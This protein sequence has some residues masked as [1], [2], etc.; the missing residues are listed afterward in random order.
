MTTNLAIP[1]VESRETAVRWARTVFQVL[2][3]LGAAAL[4]LFPELAA[5]AALHADS[6]VWAAVG[7]YAAQAL[8]AIA[9]ASYWFNKLELEWPSFRSL[10]PA[11]FRRDVEYITDGALD[12][13]EE[14]AA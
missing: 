4:V 11:P 7:L 6:P 14:D 12:D 3:G 8:A 10:I 2:V 9:T 5:L 13:G 1:G